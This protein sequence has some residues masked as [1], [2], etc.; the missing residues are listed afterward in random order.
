MYLFFLMLHRLTLFSSAKAT[1]L[2]RILP[3]LQLH[4]K[5]TAQ[6]GGGFRVGHLHHINVTVRWAKVAAMERRHLGLGLLEG[7]PRSVL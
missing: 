6:G 4:T 7:G 1:F 3:V 5:G 2:K